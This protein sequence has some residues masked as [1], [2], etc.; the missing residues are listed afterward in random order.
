M[1]LILIT[2]LLM[3]ACG[4]NAA[5]T[6]SQPPATT[7]SI[8]Q[9]TT[10]GA[11]TPPKADDNRVLGLGVAG[12]FEGGSEPEPIPSDPTVT[13]YSGY[14]EVT[15]AD[16]IL[17]VVVP[18]EWTD[19]FSG[20]WT[21]NIFGVD[22]GT[23]GIGIVIG[24]AP[25]LE[26]WTDTWTV[27]GLFFAASPLLGGTVE[28]LLDSYAYLAD[29][30]VYDARYEYDDGVYIGALDWWSDCGGVGAAYAV[31]VARP[32]GGEFTVV[33]EITL[34]SEAD[35]EAAD[36]IASSFYVVQITGD[37]G[38]LDTELAANYGSTDV[39]AG[40][41]PD[42][43]GL[44][45]EAGGDIDVAAYLGGEC[46]GYVTAAPDLEVV[47]SGSPGGLLRFF[48]V[49]ELDGDDTV[50]VIND[51]SGGWWCSDDSYDTY[52]PTI[53]FPS[54]LDGIYD[55]W[56]G[57]YT[58]GELVPGTLAITELDGVHP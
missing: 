43:Q 55:I 25:D 24:V 45:V 15:D 21:D 48:F 36:A 27:P 6:T 38:G 13:P 18:V 29:E 46:A 28:D 12:G 52:N 32:P 56:V 50:L 49:A 41:E 58:S 1:L 4:G 16:G 22:G 7:T 26:A 20:P 5:V 19:F 57:S 8:A 14:Q 3:V 2:T 39:A 53:D 23:E 10:T 9:T 31:I 44:S 42:P 40:F 47:Y 35:L 11:E 30:C 33:I 37:G 17:S 54:A 34:I 51:P